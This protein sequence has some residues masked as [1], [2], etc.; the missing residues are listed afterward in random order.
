MTQERFRK[1]PTAPSRSDEI[2]PVDLGH[3]KPDGQAFWSAPI[4]R[5]EKPVQIVVLIKQAIGVEM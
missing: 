3:E 4:D 2:L 1:P 5:A